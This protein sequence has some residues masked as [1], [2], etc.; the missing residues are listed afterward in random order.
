MMKNVLARAPAAQGVPEP[1]LERR[2]AA[3]GL[4]DVLEWSVQDGG[5]TLH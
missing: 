3:L 5:R 4:V 2:I 1:T